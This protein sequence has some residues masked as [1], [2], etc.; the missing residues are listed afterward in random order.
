MAEDIPVDVDAAAQGNQGAVLSAGGHE[1]IIAWQGDLELLNAQ[2]SIDSGRTVDLRIVE[3][4]GNNKVHPFKQYYQRRGGR[5]GQSFVVTFVPH[6]SEAPNLNGEAMLC[7]WGD[8]SNHG[9]WFRLWLDD[10][11]SHHPFGG[12]K[13]R[14]DKNLGDLFVGVFVLTTEPGGAAVTDAEHEQD[15]KRKNFRPSQKAHLLIGDSFF[16]AW[17]KE[18]SDFTTKLDA[19]GRS[20][21]KETAKSYVKWAL[22]IESLS[23]LDRNDD[24]LRRFNERFQLPYAK[25]RGWL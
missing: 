12:Y 18:K 17:L 16:M 4:A 15:A 6:G 22:K 10:E 13:R 14:S 5:A 9:Q 24:A 1:K 19:K 11:A 8:T 20:W 23:D 3:V 21:D 2:W 25:W 7:A